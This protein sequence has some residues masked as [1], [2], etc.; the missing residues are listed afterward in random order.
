MTSVVHSD[1]AINRQICRMV[2]G[3]ELKRPNLAHVFGIELRRKR[4]R[5]DQVAE[6]DGEV[7]TFRAL[8]RRR[9]DGGGGLCGGC[10]RRTAE[11]GNRLQQ[12]LSVSER[13]AEFLE[14]P[15][16]QLRQHLAVELL[17]GAE[18]PRPSPDFHVSVP[19]RTNEIVVHYLIRQIEPCYCLLA[20][21]LSV[22]S[23][24][25]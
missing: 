9:L 19:L 22:S 5:A 21:P 13:H 1:Q 18:A 16:A 23:S 6:H 7:A 11:G 3:H 2:S 14:V 10:N 8:L 17:S 4:G 12:P 24:N 15:F 20:R 25:P